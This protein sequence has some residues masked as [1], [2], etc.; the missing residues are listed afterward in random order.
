MRLRP[1]TTHCSWR[2]ALDFIVPTVLSADSAISRLPA[3][4]R[5]NPD[6]KQSMRSQLRLACQSTAFFEGR[7]RNFG[8][9]QVLGRLHDEP[10]HAQQGQASENLHKAEVP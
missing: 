7:S 5:C 6:H 2:A 1:S 4:T 3:I 9:V 8:F 10:I